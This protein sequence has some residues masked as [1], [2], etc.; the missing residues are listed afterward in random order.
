MAYSPDYDD[1]LARLLAHSEPE[2]LQKTINGYHQL[3]VTDPTRTSITIGSLSTRYIAYLLADWIQSSN[4]NRL[5]SYANLSARM[6]RMSYVYNPAAGLAYGT[7]R[8]FTALLSDE[9]DINHWFAWH[10][11]P[12]LAG[13]KGRVPDYL[14]PNKLQ[15][16]AFNCHL[17]LLGEFDWLAERTELALAGDQKFKAGKSYKHDFLFFKALA[18]GD[19][20]GME[21]NIHALLKG[22]VAY[23]RNNEN[24]MAYQRKVVSTWGI[25]LSKMAYRNGHELDIDSPWVPKE[26]LPVKPLD[27]YEYPDELK[28][29]EEFDVFS[30][31]KGESRYFK[32]ASQFAPV[33]PSAEQPNIREWVEKVVRAYP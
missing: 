12:C 29:V 3:I 21:D 4:L 20:A 1:E 7:F 30:P 8:M 23:T 9:P 13:A 11:I 32:N 15:F 2:A 16:H 6:K 5:K 24:G 18:E 10:V 31:F 19:K 14:Q 25:M 22:R 33:H 27:N 26:W 17:A 28:F